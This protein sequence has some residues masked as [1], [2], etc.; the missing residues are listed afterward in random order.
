M[1][2]IWCMVPEILSITDRIFCHFGPFFPL[3]PNNLKNQNFD[4]L[5]K[6]PGNIIILQKCTKIMIICYTIP[7]IWHV[8]DVIV[9]FH[10]GLF[11]ALLRPLT[12]LN[13][14]ISKKWKTS[15][16]IPSFYTC[17]PKLWLD[18]VRFL[19]NGARQTDGRKKW[20]RVP[21]LKRECYD[22]TQIAMPKQ[23]VAT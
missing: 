19:R 5:K 2:I 14:K 22:T 17:V 18:E 16:D 11:F 7:E 20:H 15:L 6:T 13:I 9:I 23:E 1:T 12:A 8:T 10:F 3:L 21:R 4:K